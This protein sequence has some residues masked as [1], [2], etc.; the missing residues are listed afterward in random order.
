MFFILIVLYIFIFVKYKYCRDM[1]KKIIYL[2]GTVL[3]SISLLSCDSEGVH[4]K[5]LIVASQTRCCFG[6]GKQTCL[7]VKEHKNQK[8]TLHYGGIEGFSHQEGYEYILSV[9]EIEIKEPMMD[10]LSA[11]TVLINIIRKEKKQSENLPE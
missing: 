9:K 8:W 3:F 4:S 1:V 2:L 6:E 7:L 10:G 11:K 5:I